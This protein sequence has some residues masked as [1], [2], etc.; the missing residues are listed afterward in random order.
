MSFLSR[1]AV[2]AL[3]APLVFCSLP[4]S[5]QTV[6]LGSAES[7]GVLGAS[8]V[9]NTG[10]SIVTGDLGISPN[11]ESSVTGFTFSTPPGPGQVVGT[12]HF[13]DALA[14]EAQLDATTAYNT[15]A[16]LA[17]DATIAADLGGTTLMPG[18][19]C[20]ASTMGLTGTV[21]LDAQGDPDALFVFQVGSMLTTASASSVQVINGGQACNV[22]WQIGS[23]AT[24]GTGTNFVGTIIASASVTM[25]TGVT[26]SGRAIARSGAVTMDG[27]A[28]TV[29]ELVGAVPSITKSFSPTTIAPDGLSTLTVTLTNPD[30]AAATLLAPLVDN[31]PTGVV[32]APVPN[33]TTTC[34][35]GVQPIAVAGTSTLTLPT[36]AVIPADASC[37][38]TVDV[39]ASAPGTYTNTIAASALVTSNGN[40]PDPA[41]AVLV[42]AAGVAATVSIPTLSQWTLAGL[43]MLLALF[44]LS[45]ARRRNSRPR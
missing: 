38:V 9:T 45:A 6:P 12:T 15:L 44:G 4:I 42:V 31:L 8:A 43:A 21:T 2:R 19:Y 7:F 39:T 27:N 20:S 14:M 3:L 40:N 17:C 41:V 13:A 10:P 33:A 29:C 16:G 11:G 28:V 32:I 37:T 35:G 18:V 34:G 30:P 5:A 36:G 24:L 26:S 25:T 22:F 1:I 23:S